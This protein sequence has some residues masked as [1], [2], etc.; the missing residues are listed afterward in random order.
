MPHPPDPLVSHIHNAVIHGLNATL[1]GVIVQR[2]MNRGPACSY[3]AA[4]VWGLSPAHAGA[5]AWAAGRTGLYATLFMLMSIWFMLRWLDG[6]HRTRTLSLVCFA[7]ALLSKELAIALPLVVL[8]IGYCA[9]DPDFRVIGAWRHGWPYLAVL[10][11]YFLWRLIL[12]GQIGGYESGPLSILDTIGGLFVWIPRIANPLQYSG[13]EYLAQLTGQDLS[14]TRW[15]GFLPV[16]LAMLIMFRWPD[17]GMLA[18]LGVLFLVCVV[19]GY[20]LWPNTDNLRDL[21]LFY[22]PGIVVAALVTYSWRTGALALL[23]VPLP[24]LQLQTEYETNWQAMRLQHQ[25]LVRSAREESTFNTIFVYGLARLNEAQTAVAF[26]LGVDRLAQP[27]FAPPDNTRRCLALRPL[28]PGPGTYQLPYGDVVGVPCEQTFSFE[29][30]NTL[31]GLGRPPLGRLTLHPSEPVELTMEVLQ[32]MWKGEKDPQVRI[33]GKRAFRYRVTVFT[34][35]GYLTTFLEDEGLP[36]SVN[37]LFSIKKLL[38]ASY[39]E[40]GPAYDMARALRVPTALDLDPSF[41]VLVELDENDRGRKDHVFDATH[42]NRQPL[43][44]RLDRRFGTI[45]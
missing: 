8:V 33:L 27:P 3:L 21:R 5:V 13:Y 43:Y 7:L 18:A 29:S 2:L 23:L 30:P 37:G 40:K 6:K 31:A 28:I 20:Q 39:R 4:L 15:L 24:F 1:V 41:P 16:P 44:L 14:W 45:R 17:R 38:L 22:L 9:A 25:E 34:A 42:A 32:Q 19:P 11:A 35:D 36:D 10:A 26:H 12:F